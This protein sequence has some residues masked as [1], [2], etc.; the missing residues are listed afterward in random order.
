MGGS[1]WWVRTSPSA[2]TR[3]TLSTDVGP[4][5]D[6]LADL[7]LLLQYHFMQNALIVGTIVA[8]LGGGIGYFAVLLGPRFAPPLLSPG[9]F[10]V[11]S[12]TPLFPPP[13]LPPLPLFSLR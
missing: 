9:G 10:P 4:S 12:V 8:V 13:P 6:L 11:P 5:W 3:M 1:S 2:T 7:Q